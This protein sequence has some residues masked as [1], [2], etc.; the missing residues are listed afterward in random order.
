MMNHNTV[1]QTVLAQAQAGDAEALEMIRDFY[2][3][4]GDTVEDA[5]AADTATDAE[6]C[7]MFEE[8]CNEH[9]KNLRRN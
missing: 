3:R 7:R 8:V 5:V 9:D 4:T 6:L 2:R 1:R